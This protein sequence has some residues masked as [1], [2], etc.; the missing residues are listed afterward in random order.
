MSRTRSP[1]RSGSTSISSTSPTENK[2][3]RRRKVPLIERI[4][5]DRRKDLRDRISFYSTEKVHIYLKNVVLKLFAYM[6]C[7]LL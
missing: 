3:E 4:T 5:T 1:P 6:Y 7:R 2:H